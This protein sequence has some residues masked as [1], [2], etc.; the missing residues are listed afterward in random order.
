[1][2][3]LVSIIDEWRNNRHYV[4]Q[5]W[6]FTHIMLNNKA[7]QWGVLTTTLLPERCCYVRGVH[8]CRARYPTALQIYEKIF[9]K[10]SIHL[11]ISVL[12]TLMYVNRSNAVQ[13]LLIKTKKQSSPVIESHS[14]QSSQIAL[15]L[16]QSESISQ[17]KH[18][19]KIYGSWHILTHR[20]SKKTPHPASLAILKVRVLR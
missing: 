18:G 11:K 2:L 8:L 19:S 13:S 10:V 12:L 9:F 1:M 4:Q 6:F 14:I 3:G 15:P 17:T 5:K 16:W 20:L 7:S